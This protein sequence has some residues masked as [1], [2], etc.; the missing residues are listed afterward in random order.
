ML[1][2]NFS[3]RNERISQG[4]RTAACVS[5][6]SRM[7]NNSMYVLLK[8]LKSGSVMMLPKISVGAGRLSKLGFGVFALL[9][10]ALVAAAV[11][12][13]GSFI[14]NRATVQFTD[15]SSGIVQTI[16][17][18]EVRVQI[19]PKEGVDI[20]APKEVTRSAGRAFCFAHQITN[21]GNT[22]SDLQLSY[23]QVSGGNEDVFNPTNI[24]IVVEN[25][26]ANGVADSDEQSFVLAEGVLTAPLDFDY[27]GVLNVL[28]C[29]LVPPGQAAGD[30]A[31][32]LLTATTVEQ[33]AQ[34]NV[35][36]SLDVI[37]G[38]DLQVNLLASTSSALPGDTVGLTVTSQNVGDAPA[39]AT[40]YT[41]DGNER[42]FVLIS[43]PVPPNT[44]FNSIVDVPAGLVPL[45]HIAGTPADQY[46]AV[47]PADLSTVDAVSFGVPDGYPPGQ[48]YQAIIDL[49]VNDDASGQVTA[50]ALLEQANP[51]NPNLRAQVVSNTA[52]IDLPDGEAVLNNYSDNTYAVIQDALTEIKPLFLQVSAPQCNVDPLVVGEFK[53]R[54]R[55]V[56]AGDLETI[57]IVET[58]PNT[59][60]F[61]TDPRALELST[62][63][64]ISGDNVLQVTEDDGIE[65]E[66]QT[67]GVCAV[68]G[69]LRV[70][71]VPGVTITIDKNVS[72]TRSEVGGIVT[73]TIVVANTSDRQ[74]EEVVV[75]D[76]GAFGFQRLL[77]SASYLNGAANASEVPIREVETIDFAA[78][79]GQVIGGA[80]PLVSF[81]VGQLEPDNGVS[82][83]G[84]EVTITYRTKL[85]PGAVRSDGINTAVASAK[86]A[87]LATAG[88]QAVDNSVN[89]DTRLTAVAS[90]QATAQVIVDAGVFSE[91]GYIIG[92]VYA[93]CD[94]NRQQGHE[95]IG[96]PGIRIYMNDGTYVVTDSEGKYSFYGLEPK[97]WVLKLDN[98]TLPPGFLPKALDNRHAG[99][100]DSRFVDLTAGELHRADFADAGCFPEMIANVKARRAKGEVFSP[101]IE[102]NLDNDLLNER[103]F[104]TDVK[105]RPASGLVDAQNDIQVEEFN[106]SEFLNE[107]NSTLPGEALSA[108]PEV[109]LETLVKAET[110]NEFGF[111]G[112]EN[113]AVMPRDKM[114]I[115]LK[116]RQQAQFK[117]MV[118]SVEVPQSRVGQVVTNNASGI[119]AWEFVSV[120]L[121]PG[122]N[123]LK[124][125]Q[126]D[127]FGN[128]RSEK[129]VNVIV[130]DNLAN[131]IIRVPNKPI[132]DGSSVWVEV[133]LSDQNGTR[134]NARTQVTLEVD[135]GRWL[136]DDVNPDEPGW[137][138]FVEGG[139]TRFELA[140]PSSP[141]EI[142]I[143]ATTGQLAEEA[144]INFLPDLRPMLAVGLI[145]GSISFSDNDSDTPTGSDRFARELNNF[146]DTSDDDYEAGM[147]GSIFA[148]GRVLDNYLLTARYESEQD[149]DDVLFRDIQP[150]EFYPVYGD[151]SQRGF[152]AQS[153]SD[154]YVR[155][156]RGRNYLQY[157]DFSTSDGNSVLGLARYNRSMTGLKGHIETDS[158][159]LNLF[160]AEDSTRQVSLELRGQGISGPY[161][162]NAADPTD[163][164]D[165]LFASDYVRNSEQV[166][167]IVR[168]RGQESIVLDV[169]QLTRFSDYQIDEQ[170]GLILFR[171]PIQS[172]DQELNPIYIRVT[173]EVD[174]GGDDYITA[175]GSLEW[176]IADNL[177]VS[178]TY[179][180]DE[181]PAG[182]VE[183]MGAGVEFRPWDNT[184]VMLEHAVTVRP[185]GAADDLKGEANRAEVRLNEGRLSANL[186]AAKTDPD[187][188]T[189]SGQA[190]ISPT[191]ITG[192]QN[193]NTGTLGAGREEFGLDMTLRIT[194][195]TNLTLDAYKTEDTATSGSTDEREHISVA[196]SQRFG[197]YLTLELNVG[198]TEGETANGTVIDDRTIGGR[199]TTKLPYVDNSSAFV[200]YK[201]DTNDQDQSLLAFGAEAPVSQRTK[202]YARHEIRNTLDSRREGFT[203]GQRN[204]TVFGFS[205]SYMDNQG[206]LFSEY[207]ARDAFD[208]RS[209]EAA[210]GVRHGW[211]LFD[212]FNLD[213]S[214]E[215][216]RSI[217]TQTAGQDV[218]AMS[219]AIAA[220]Y[221]GDPLW[222]ATGRLEWRQS[223]TRRSWLNT[224]GLGRKLSRDWTFLG[225]NSITLDQ[226]RNTGDNSIRDR[227][228]LGLAWRE[229][230]RNRWAV[231]ARYELDY[232]DTPSSTGEDSDSLSHIVSAHL[233]YKP[234][235]AWS[236]S[237]RYAYKYT[238]ETIG[239]DKTNFDMHLVSARATYDFAERWD[240]GVIASTIFDDNANN[241]GL[242]LELGYLVAAN[243][244][245][246]A[247]YNI[248]G[249][250]DDE[251]LNADYTSE[252][253]FIRFRYK[254][255]ENLF[256]GGDPYVNNL[257]P[258]A[259][260]PFEE[261]LRYDAE[262]D[263][264]HA[265]YVR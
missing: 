188:N 105:A 68:S 141:M 78:A 178:G 84:D 101:E 16:T 218:D 44:T 82:G 234:V 164:S 238:G 75:E 34:D 115:M 5:D 111:I 203:D 237:G 196:V 207:R 27:Q 210:I 171:G 113:N 26:P 233:N 174:E 235:E 10:S 86:L 29:G 166:E 212:G 250:T 241:Y 4:G 18:N 118:N 152:D 112:I 57:D 226:D 160:V 245:V 144:E 257:M 150:D 186:Y 43:I 70:S 71:L 88:A 227:L 251:Q 119:Q 46:T 195:S 64:V 156:D 242:G 32:L 106:L 87:S 83:G 65:A 90:V 211:E 187:Y 36:D 172:L 175:G 95:E 12:I 73:Y 146:T 169:Q 148:K 157:G 213:A 263:V 125:Q 123:E 198:Q 63:A 217:E 107:D 132:A 22:D 181:N 114:S 60:V 59:G 221:V 249:Y 53:V 11:P 19:L 230:D 252:G 167:L 62:A 173:Y 254:F 67:G 185:N 17:T 162:G 209:A 159:S 96:I 91:R 176:K 81:Y 239:N 94:F 45:Y 145:E 220:D 131:M 93:D 163:T 79:P 61:R 134:I 232:N 229:T 192:S 3:K 219:A 55:S 225:R 201:R 74:L 108:R 223:Q 138:V 228:Q 265:P 200:E 214:F 224:L 208:G 149:E 216:V 135:R 41:V 52:V 137:Q 54:V 102:K 140:S 28:L 124:A 2:R 39:V 89:A 100:G 77:N 130:A 33:N 143:R 98:T 51:D 222:K 122:R 155:L 15:D 69:V 1:I 21:T 243:L 147:R 248:F 206:S 153:T 258:E 255:D 182:E 170:R 136:T 191:Q 49:T 25:E 126:I 48:N 38:P 116:G 58:G 92:K 165:R 23:G 35:T 6:K 30:G 128:V 40:T 120:D 202:M 215:Q 261:S 76:R 246:S 109:D 110:S 190:R 262:N 204:Q 179:V 231:L 72:P 47:P 20:D 14:E 240:V 56:L 151:S 205:T 168:R 85:G 197:E 244:W 129:V 13:A 121:A 260:G 264:Q 180:T 189:S 42:D 194:D 259:A 253:A 247:G 117:L 9:M 127:Q 184:T 158:L 154:V 7:I 161:G 193:V 256:S 66:F 37:A 31:Q 97:T 103:G 199:I 133:A 8:T 104:G 50:V 177:A 142:N 99:V 24:S 139:L 80:G 183:V 236:V